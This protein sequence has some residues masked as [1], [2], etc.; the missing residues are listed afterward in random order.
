M[1]IRKPQILGAAAQLR[2]AEAR[3]PRDRPASVR[4]AAARHAAA[5]PLLGTVVRLVRAGGRRHVLPADEPVPPGVRTAGE[6]EVA[7]VGPAGEL[8]L[9][10]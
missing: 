10:P 8:E 7:A 6:F 4:A 3:G 2:A 5:A 9:R 1:I